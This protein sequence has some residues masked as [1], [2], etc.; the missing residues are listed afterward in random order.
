[1]MRWRIK[2]TIEN[3]R[4]KRR[5]QPKLRTS[6]PGTSADVRSTSRA[7]MTKMKRPSVSRV[8]GRVRMTRIGLRNALTNPN[9]RAASRPAK[10]FLTVTPGSR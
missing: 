10:K 9:T 3:R 4:L 7:L 8:I 6:K 2:L 1:M 5:A